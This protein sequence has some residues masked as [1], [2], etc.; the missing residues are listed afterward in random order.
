[1]NAYYV[2]EYEVLIQGHRKTIDLKVKVIKSFGDLEIMVRKIR[3][4]IH[5]LFTSKKLPE[6]VNGFD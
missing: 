1:M 2:A 5:C 3:N 6:G 4:K